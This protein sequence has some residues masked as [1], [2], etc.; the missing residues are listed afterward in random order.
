MIDDKQKIEENWLI[1][2]L[3]PFFLFKWNPYIHQE[4]EFYIKREKIYDKEISN[5]NPNWTKRNEESF[6]LLENLKYII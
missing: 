3:P 1:P 6:S 4:I 2:Q 5:K